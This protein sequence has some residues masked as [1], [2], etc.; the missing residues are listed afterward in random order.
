[1]LDVFSVE[2][3]TKVM[4]CATCVFRQQIISQLLP[5]KRSEAEVCEHRC[6]T[7]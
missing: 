7:C 2:M 5:K 4:G 6:E 3:Y 1:M